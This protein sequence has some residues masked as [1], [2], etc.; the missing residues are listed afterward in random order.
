VGYD[1]VLVQRPR[2]RTGPYPSRAFVNWLFGKMDLESTNAS[3]GEG[4]PV[5]PALFHS[6]PRRLKLNLWLLPFQPALAIAAVPRF[7]EQRA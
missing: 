5:A 1:C 4:W 2:R 3:V 6:S 7:D